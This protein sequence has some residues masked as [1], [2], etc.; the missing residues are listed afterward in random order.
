MYGLIA[1]GHFDA[2]HFLADYHGKCEN[3]HG[4]RWRVEVVVESE[5]LGQEGTERAMV[6]DFGRFKREVASVCD[7][8][9]HRLLVEQGTLKPTTIEALESEGFALEVLPFRT[10]AENLA[11]E[12]FCRLEARGLPVAQVEVDETPANRAFYRK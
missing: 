2:A 3:L 4:H 1:E 12:I 6:Q 7:E 8:F 9:D 10:T 5:Q 11:H